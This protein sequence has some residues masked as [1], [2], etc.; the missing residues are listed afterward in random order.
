M[1]APWVGYVRVSH[2][3]GR[4]GDSFRS[5]TDQATSIQTWAA[6]RGDQVVILDPELD[7]SGGSRDRPILAAAVAGIEAGQYRGLV[8]AY[9]SRAGRSVRHLLEMW[10]RFAP[11]LAHS[12]AQL[13]VKRRQR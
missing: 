9:L 1:G 11:A 10:D 4:A 5:P 8:V 12:L 13:K 2:V 3:G 6:T 7:E